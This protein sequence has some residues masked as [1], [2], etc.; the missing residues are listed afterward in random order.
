M[1]VVNVGMDANWLG[2]HLAMANL[3]GYGRLAWNPNVSSKTIA[4]EWTRLTF[5]NDPEVV[6]TI[7][8][9]AIGIMACL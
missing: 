6:Q 8:R 4:Q 1:A 5:G 9:Y 2:S 7:T 3:Y